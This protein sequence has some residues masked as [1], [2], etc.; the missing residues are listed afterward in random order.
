MKNMAG[1][2]LY[3][4]MAVLECGHVESL[5]QMPA[6]MGD[7]VCARMTS[8][9]CTSCGVARRGIGGV[10]RDAEDPFRTVTY[11]GLWDWARWERARDERWH[12]EHVRSL[13]HSMGWC[14]C[15]PEAGLAEAS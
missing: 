7:V 5:R 12:R 3:D 10:H 13:G 6:R 4:W 14:G 8:H 11:A 9:R 15:E 2:E 1:D